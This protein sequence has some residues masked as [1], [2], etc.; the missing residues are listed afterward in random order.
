L[1]SIPRLDRAE[2][3]PLIPIEGAPPD[4]RQA[5]VGCP[6]APRCAW[7]L[8]ACW[9]ENP[10]LRATDGSGAAIRTG[11]DATHQVACH[12]LPTPEEAEA[13]RPLRPGFH[14]APAPGAIA[15]ELARDDMAAAAVARAGVDG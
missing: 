9:A 5:L 14:P 7:R 2:D 12:N 6:F 13:G 8:E 4:Q 11:P 15:D 10:V 1:H 3:D